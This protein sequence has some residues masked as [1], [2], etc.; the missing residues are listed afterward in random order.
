MSSE[1]VSL[2]GRRERELESGDRGAAVPSRVADWRRVCLYELRQSDMRLE[3]A[4]EDGGVCSRGGSKPKSGFCARVE[5]PGSFTTS[6]TLYLWYSHTLSA[7]NTP[8]TSMPPPKIHDELDDECVSLALL[9]RVPPPWDSLTRITA[10]T[11][12]TTYST[13]SR[14]SPPPRP[15]LLLPPPRPC[16]LR[17]LA[18]PPH[19]LQRQQRTTTTSATQTMSA[20]TRSTRSQQQKTR[21]SRANSNR[22]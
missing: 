10:S 16:H 20:S 11:T 14:L 19:H 17:L 3:M 18:M 2:V 1:V 6:A 15:R 22:A 4:A 13:R 8:P 12:S 7:E 5:L 9:G 21:N